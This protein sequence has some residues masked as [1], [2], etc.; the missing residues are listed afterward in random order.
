MQTC[1]LNY[2][3]VYCNVNTHD[4]WEGNVIMSEV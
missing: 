4:I 3:V 2:L 1:G